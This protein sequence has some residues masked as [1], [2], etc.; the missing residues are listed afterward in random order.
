MTINI[1]K[2]WK[3]SP[4][5]NNCGI[6]SLRDDI[7]FWTRFRLR[8]IR[9]ITVLEFHRA[10]QAWLGGNDGGM[11]YQTATDRGNF[12]ISP[13]LENKIDRVFQLQ[14]SWG[15]HPDSLKV[16]KHGP[17][18][19]ADGTEILVP[20]HG[21]IASCVNWID[22]SPFRKVIGFILPFLAI[23]GKVFGIY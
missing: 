1:S 12:K 11:A 2:Y 3:V 13:K 8:W 5:H 14:H 18:L 20:A 23:A 16:L 10:V 15:I 21:A 17:L 9:R 7:S 22:E 19:N 6:I 4:D